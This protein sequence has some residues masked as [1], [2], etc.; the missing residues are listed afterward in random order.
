MV[1]GLWGKP[2]YCTRNLCY[3]WKFRVVGME[4]GYF[5]VYYG[6][7]IGDFYNLKLTVLLKWINLYLF[8]IQ[9]MS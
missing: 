1:E 5:E 8:W 6:V 9:Q 3:S 7:K 4:L 2:K